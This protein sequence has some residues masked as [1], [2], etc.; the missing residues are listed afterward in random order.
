MEQRDRH[1]PGERQVVYV[2][3]ARE[4]GP[5]DWTDTSSDET[6]RED[7]SSRRSETPPELS[8][9]HKQRERTSSRDLPRQDAADQETVDIHVDEPAPVAVLS[10]GTEVQQTP[11]MI[12][13]HAPLMSV[14]KTSTTT[15]EWP[16]GDG[17][18]HVEDEQVREQQTRSGSWLPEEGVEEDKGA[19]LYREDESIG[20]Y[21]EEGGAGSFR[22]DGGNGFYREDGNAGS[23]KEDETSAASKEEVGPWE[24][25]SG[26][27]R[28]TLEGEDS[29]GGEEYDQV[30]AQE[31]EYYEPIERDAEARAPSRRREKPPV[32]RA[33]KE[34]QREQD[35]Q[36]YREAQMISYQQRLRPGSSGEGVRSGSS[37]SL[38]DR[39]VLV[40]PSRR[41]EEP[42]PR[43][44]RAARP[45]RIVPQELGA[46]LR[47]QPRGQDSL[48]SDDAPTRLRPL[49]L[50]E[51]DGP[52]RA[53]VTSEKGTDSARYE[54]PSRGISGQIQ[55][56]AAQSPRLSPHSPR[57]SPHSPRLSP[58]S[59]RPASQSSK[60]SPQSPRSSPQSPKSS[61]QSPRQSSHTRRDP[62]SRS[63]E[64]PAW[65]LALAEPPTGASRVPAWR[66]ALVR[67]SLQSALGSLDE[68]APEGEAHA[69]A[70]ELT[71]ELQESSGDDPPS[72]VGIATTLHG[73]TLTVVVSRPDGVAKED[74]D[75][76]TT[77]KYQIVLPEK[78]KV[79]AVA[80]ATDESSPQRE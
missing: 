62:V 10:T 77:L 60:S 20:L 73:D 26:E 25:D 80:K 28:D 52:R 5:Y 44:R 59:P 67:E 38:G 15:S 7:T 23:F 71:G 54:T 40:A 3:E 6:E 1:Q 56:Q 48:L 11:T 32:Q 9:R 47:L 33:Q 61:P 74:Q 35:K 27:G 45:A 43:T 16:R 50:R 78:R 65:T 4:G 34:A 37:A 22:E 31:A 46:E 14:R 41:M 69:A 30:N 68:A 55:I 53:V 12:H 39:R 18:V 21:R 63:Q 64:R 57:L 8:D 29:E 2:G 36:L 51:G 70:L 58:H 75:S 17:I 72:G 66:R 19:G 49:A 13:P 76:S 79:T 24:R 42:L